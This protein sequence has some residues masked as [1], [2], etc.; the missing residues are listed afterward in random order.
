ML[1]S[2]H[3]QYLTARVAVSTTLAWMVMNVMAVQLLFYV[4][5]ILPLVIGGVATSLARVSNN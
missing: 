5:R 1:T 4:I 2:Q 3:I